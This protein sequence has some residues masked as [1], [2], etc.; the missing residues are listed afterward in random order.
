MFRYARQSTQEQK[1]NKAT[2]EGI[3]LTAGLAAATEEKNKWS[4]VQHGTSRDM[5]MAI[6]H[7]SG[8]SAVVP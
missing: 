6:E 8:A 3:S 5:N 7:F 4:R 1:Q 2:K